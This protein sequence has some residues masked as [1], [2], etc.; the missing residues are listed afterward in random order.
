MNK[1]GYLKHKINVG[2]SFNI[3]EV[4]YSFILNIRTKYYVSTGCI[5]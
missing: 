1:Y 4:S 3:E 2:C 5:K